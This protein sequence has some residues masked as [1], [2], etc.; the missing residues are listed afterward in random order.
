MRGKDVLFSSKSDDW[1][2]PQDLWDELNSEFHFTLDGAA[3]EENHKCPMWLGPGSPFGPYFEDS[4]DAKIWVHHEVIWLNP[5]YSMMKGFAH[6]A[7]YW[8]RNCNTVVMLV[9]S[10]TDTAWWHAAV[11]DRVNHCPREGV[12]VR[13]VKGRLKFGGATAGAPFPS[14]IV[15]FRSQHDDG[16]D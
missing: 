16:N 15:V 7:Y 13:F 8:Q 5:P 11:W 3:N 10:R 4:S 14:A 2:T 1:S 9:P 6:S 12:Q